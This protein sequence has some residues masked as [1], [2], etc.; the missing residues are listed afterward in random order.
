MN[1]Q[2]TLAWCAEDRARIDRLTEALEDFT[3]KAKDITPTCDACAKTVAEGVAHYIGDQQPKLVITKLEP[4]DPGYTSHENATEST[5][6]ETPAT[7]QPVEET[8]AQTEDA[9]VA[10][11]KPAVTL[12]QIQQK[13]IQ[14]AA[15]N[16]GAK[17]AQVR[18]IVNAYATKVS[19][20]PE[21]TWDE[22][23]E[24]LTAL[25]KGV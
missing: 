13:V 18:G 7:V 10:E 20:L 19:D 24:K 15:A 11:V 14:L 1:N 4:G 25:E 22:V 3:R 8:P 16:G 2:I 12:E 21:S 5:E 17:K 23:W 6:A 9:P